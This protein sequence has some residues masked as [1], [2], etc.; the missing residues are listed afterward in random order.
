MAKAIVLEHPELSCVRIDLDPKD[1]VTSQ[2]GSLLNEMLSTSRED[3]I[4]YRKN[5]RYV[6]R[7][8]HHKDQQANREQNVVFHRNATYLISGGKTGL[9]ML[10][11]QWMAAQGA[12]HLV[13]IARSEPTEKETEQLTNLESTGATVSFIRADVSNPQQMRQVLEQL[14]ERFPPLRGVVHSAGVLDD[15]LLE[16]QTWD[17]FDRVFGPKV[18]GALNLHSL[19]L[20]QPL[21]FFVLFSSAASLLGAPGQ[22]NHSAANA[23]LDAL[24]HHRRSLGLPALSIN[25]GAWSV[26]GSGASAAVSARMAMHGMGTI[27]PRQG[28]NIL[29]YLL[30]GTATQVGAIPMNWSQV[31]QQFAHGTEPPFLSVITGHERR[32]LQTHT[33]AKAPFTLEDLRERPST[34]RSE[35]L[36][37][38]LQDRIASCLRL[39][40]SGVALHK[41]LSHM[42]LDSLMAIEI[43]NRIKH[44]VGLEIPVVK[45]MEALSVSELANE[46]AQAA[47][48]PDRHGPDSCIFNLA[49][50][51]TPETARVFLSRVDQLSDDEMNTL[52]EAASSLGQANGSTGHVL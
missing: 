15:A 17:R 14:P 18:A 45:F 26:I 22:A 19:T 20:Q 7:L 50:A 11:A 39:S 48:P 12:G 38:Y 47:A 49:S 36:T 23:F 44:E 43:R 31:L 29:Q 37:E 46:L 28:V 41:P 3:Q 10:A 30:S 52:L 5:Q 9:G 42:G 2:S 51:I 1:R 33:P 27:S 21:D 13:L 32:K 35:L 6:A 24:A 34:Q 25:W 40:D 8:V 4:A 16:Q